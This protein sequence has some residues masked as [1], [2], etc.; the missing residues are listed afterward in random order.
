MSGNLYTEFISRLEEKYGKWEKGT[1][2]F[3]ESSYGSITDDLCISKSQFTVLI[4]N[5]GTDGMYIRS[6]RNVEQLL[7]Y[8]Q[9]KSD[10]DE[11]R[12]L[13]KNTPN[14]LP[15]ILGLVCLFLLAAFFIKKSYNPTPEKEMKN[16]SIHP[17]SEYFDGDS[18]SNYVSPYLL[19]TEVQNYCPCSAYEGEWKLEKE[20]IIPLP[21]KKPGLYYLAKSSDVRV[22]CQK[23]AKEADRGKILI[24][25]ENM[26]NEL[27]LDKDRN[28]FSPKYFD[29]E[30]KSY[31]AEFINLDIEKAP[32]FVK[33]ADVY[34]CFYDQFNIQKEQIIRKGEPCGRYAKNINQ[35]IVE[36][37]GVDVE[38]ILK[39]IISSMAQIECQPTINKYCNPNALEENKSTLEY[40]CMFKIST[41]NLGIGGGYPYTKGYLLVKQNYSDNL[42]CNCETSYE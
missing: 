13:Q 36:Q 9:Q 17:F 29:Q 7:Q 21:S 5:K 24:G 3:G 33:V 15:L 11:I 12:V 38:H 35:E 41:E 22:K 27:W 39:N 16:L 19:E 28:S 20:Y 31:T 25:F 34:S 26:H 18:K 6:I 37:Y 30:T 32:N 10:L 4:S 23:G 14:R 42:I 40:N 8:D 2:N 1:S